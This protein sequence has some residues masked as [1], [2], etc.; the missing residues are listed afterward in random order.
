MKK[1]R[2][3]V[4]PLRRGT[5]CLINSIRHQPSAYGVESE[6][7]DGWQTQPRSRFN[8]HVPSG[9][10]ER[11]GRCD[12]PAIRFSREFVEDPLDM[13]GVPHAGTPR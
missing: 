6:G 3:S 1:W 8:D 2:T 13:V 11:S 5:E 12:K 7:I 4:I 9:R 10:S